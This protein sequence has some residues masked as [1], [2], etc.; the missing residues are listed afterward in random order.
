MTRGSGRGNLQLPRVNGSTF[1][2]GGEMSY[3][4]TVGFTY[5]FREVRRSHLNEGKPIRDKTSK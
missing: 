3:V 5:L 1:R 2:E 4:T